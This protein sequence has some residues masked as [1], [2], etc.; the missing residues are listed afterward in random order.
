M[1]TLRFQEV[2]QNIIERGDNFSKSTTFWNERINS[3][4]KRQ[5]KIFLNIWLREDEIVD[6]KTGEVL[7]RYVD[8]STS[9]EYRQAGWSG[10]KFWLDS[11]ACNGGRDKAINFVRFV[12]QFKGAKK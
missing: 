11:E 9:Q 4:V 10:W 3:T 8:Y 12:G 1:Q 7:A 6:A 2:P 5:G